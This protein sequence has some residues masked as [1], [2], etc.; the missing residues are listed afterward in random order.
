MKLGDLTVELEVANKKLK[1]SRVL[2]ERK[3]IALGELRKALGH[4]GV[5]IPDLGPRIIDGAIENPSAS[6]HSEAY[7]GQPGACLHNPSD[8]MSTAC[9]CASCASGSSWTAARD[10]YDPDSKYGLINRRPQQRQSHHQRFA[11]ADD[12]QTMYNNSA[13]AM[14]SDRKRTKKSKAAKSGESRE[15]KKPKG[16][17][18]TKSKSKT[19][20]SKAKL[21]KRSKRMSK[22]QVSMVSSS[23]NKETTFSQ[24][25]DVV[26]PGLQ[27]F[28]R[29]KEAARREHERKEAEKAEE[30]ERRQRREAERQARHLRHL[31]SKY[32]G[33]QQEVSPLPPFLPSTDFCCSDA[34]CTGQCRRRS[35]ECE[36]QGIE[37]AE[38]TA[39]LM[40]AMTPDTDRGAKSDVSL[41]DLELNA[42][43][44]SDSAEVAGLDASLLEA[45][46]NH[47]AVEADL[48]YTNSTV[49]PES[50]L[51]LS[52]ASSDVSGDPL[53]SSSDLPLHNTAPSTTSKNHHTH[54]DRL[55]ARQVMAARRAHTKMSARETKTKA[56]PCKIHP[57]NNLPP[58]RRSSATSKS[59]A[60]ASLK[61]RPKWI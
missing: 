61:D 50:P 3:E 60:S 20:I 53:E 10:R 19:K 39:D 27:E 5:V 44:V 4:S 12:P 23:S 43:G 11:E 6:G 29:L 51:T 28:I 15:E 47:L 42:L 1:I 26:R 37:D 55:T 25:E 35:A 21:V 24:R 31:A 41:T 9:S 52:P 33:F 22:R 38:M 30:E 32:T 18:K 40:A 58:K 49:P 59:K 7:N 34:S 2:L 46:Q 14:A 36:Y 8:S 57:A 45:V 56:A 13:N 54:K 16:L 17:K 48:Q